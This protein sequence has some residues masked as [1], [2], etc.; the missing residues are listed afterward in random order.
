[1]SKAAEVSNRLRQLY[2]E[3]PARARGVLHA[4]ASWHAPDATLRVIRIRPDSPGH[5]AGIEAG[6]FLLG[7]EISIMGS[8]FE[9][10]KTEKYESLD[11]I[12]ESFAELARDRDATHRCWLLRDGKVIQRSLKILKL[13]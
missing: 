8:G 9:E 4:V 10:L 1:M 5:A 3:D 6:D 13:P 12:S 7:I 11:R 2:G